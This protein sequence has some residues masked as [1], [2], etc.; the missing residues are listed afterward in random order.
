MKFLKEYLNQWR[1][2]QFSPKPKLQ[3]WWNSKLL[4]KRNFN[5][6]SANNLGIT[7]TQPEAH[8][9]LLQQ[10]IELREGNGGGGK[11]KNRERERDL[12]FE[13]SKGKQG[14]RQ[15]TNGKN[16][17]ETRQ[18]GVIY[19]QEFGAEAGR[20]SFVKCISFMLKEFREAVFFGNQE[21][22]PIMLDDET[23]SVQNVASFIHQSK[24]EESLQ[25]ATDQEM[26]E[27]IMSRW[28][29]SCRKMIKIDYFYVIVVPLLQLNRKLGFF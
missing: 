23:V 24:E 15:L 1:L 20:L 5:S 6:M 10:Q 17:G 8:K 12:N 27:I 26:L 2:E 7:K 14:K 11:A 16:A 3:Q 22:N 18:A 29:T 19:L 25:N 21:F 9:K 4:I 28:D 13:N